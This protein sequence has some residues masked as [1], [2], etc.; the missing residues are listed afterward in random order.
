[1][2]NRVLFFLMIA[3]SMSLIIESTVK[4]SKSC[5]MSF[6]IDALSHFLWSM[7]LSMHQPSGFSRTPCM[8]KK[9]FWFVQEDGDPIPHAGLSCSCHNLTCFMLRIAYR[10][11]SKDL[12]FKTQT[13]TDAKAKAKILINWCPSPDT[14]VGG[15]LF[16]LSAIKEKARSVTECFQTKWVQTQCHS[17]E[18]L[19]VIP[20]R[21]NRR[22]CRR[23]PF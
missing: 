9:Y 10:N 11:R 22:R 12:M 21:H 7:A 8:F 6:K 1:V 17:N 14:V 18:W 19:E 16:F 20:F 23:R 13:A 15:Y 5:R 2:G 4:Q 3:E